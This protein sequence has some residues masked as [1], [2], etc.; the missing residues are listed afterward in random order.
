MA[1]YSNPYNS[2]NPVQPAA[3]SSAKSFSTGGTG[4][5]NPQQFLES[6]LPGIGALTSTATSNISS[7]LNGL[8]SPGTART[9]NAYWGVGAGTPAS[10][11]INSFIGQRGTDLYGQQAQAS[12]QTGL[13]DLL[14][15]LGA[16]SSPVLSNQGQ[17]M[18]NTQAGNQLGYDY[19]ALSQSGQEFNQNL[20]QQQQQFNSTNSLNQFQSMLSALGLGNQITGGIPQV[21]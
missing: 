1:N 3:V 14:Q 21:P 13:Q 19:S 8:P 9:A 18:Q 7:L 20:A 5:S 11:D 12:Q 17:Q 2:G 6:V 10:G 4:T 15:T 16:Y